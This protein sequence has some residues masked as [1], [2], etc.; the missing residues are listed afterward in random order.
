MLNSK[1]LVT[2]IAAQLSLGDAEKIGSHKNQAKQSGRATTEELAEFSVTVSTMSKTKNWNYESESEWNPTTFDRVVAQYQPRIYRFIYGMV[3]EAEMAHDL[4][5]D[6][7]LSAYKNLL[8]RAE[9]A[10][11]AEDAG[12][13]EELDRYNPANNNISA[14]LY[15]IARNTALSEMRRHKVVRFFSFWQRSGSNEGEEEIDGMADVAAL[16]PGGGIE[17]RFALRDELQRA[18]DKV[19]R[20]RLTALLLHLDGF[21]YKEIC[22]ITG[23]S[24]PSIKSQ[25]FRAKESLRRVLSTTATTGSSAE[26]AEEAD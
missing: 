4:T 24:L 17:T 16:E 11:L 12:L 3:G 18:M 8:K 9:A 15:T 1:A 10:Q 5:Q 2:G 13:V 23:D 21:S 20:E 14:W 6:T 25:I 22:Q 19:G 7:F 26:L